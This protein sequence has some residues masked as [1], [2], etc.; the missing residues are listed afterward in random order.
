[1]AAMPYD[2]Q[3]HQFSSLIISFRNLSS[4]PQTET[5]IISDTSMPFRWTLQKVLPQVKLLHTYLIGGIIVKLFC[6]SIKRINIITRA[7]VQHSL[8]YRVKTLFNL[9]NYG[10]EKN[11]LTHFF[12]KCEIQ[13]SSFRFKAECCGSVELESETIFASGFPQSHEL[14]TEHSYNKVNE[15]R[16][17]ARE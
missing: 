1:M 16:T 12:L 5:Q 8:I 2:A 11:S 15:P 17:S 6:A 10:A 9:I 7:T 14:S 13:P 3:R 4:G